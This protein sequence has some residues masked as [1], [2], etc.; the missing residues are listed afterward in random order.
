MLLSISDN[1][2]EKLNIKNKISKLNFAFCILIFG[3]L[4]GSFVFAGANNETVDMV[5][6]AL[7][8]D[9]PAMQSAAVSLVREISGTEFT[10]AL[11]EQFPNLGNVAQ[12]QLLL[13]LADRGDKAALPVVV[14]ATNSKD[15]SVRKA[16][17]E[18]LGKLGDS[19]CVMLLARRAADSGAEEQNAAR[20]SLYCLCGSDIDETVLS[21]IAAETEPKVKVELIRSVGERNIVQG[22][23]TLLK[24]ARDTDRAVQRESLKVLKIIAGPSYLPALIELL[25]D[26]PSESVREIAENT[27]AAV[28]RK[29]EGKNHQVGV[30]LAVLAGVE[31]TESRCS[32][33]S[34][35]GKIGDDSGLP[36]LRKALKDDEV[37]IREAAIRA[38]SDWPS[39]KP[40]SDV[41]NVARN[42]SIKL[43]KILALRGYVR[44]IGLDAESPSSEILAMYK[45][46]ME[47]APDVA[48]K[49]RVLSGVSNTR[50]LSALRMAASY[51][52]DASLQTEAESAVVKIA[53]SIFRTH[54]EPCKG[55]LNKVM[56][57]TK[58]EH[59]RQQAQDVLN[60][61]K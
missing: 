16:A 49:K 45:E 2:M 50:S 37:R 42:S 7:K 19:L 41:Q 27:V 31:K 17:L 24:S 55:A 14:D 32:L 5:I 15:C 23:D 1:E 40:L 22:V 26:I 54:Q 11:V 18:A 4:S 6:K 13:A 8:S 56:E 10:K 61:L 3:F 52:D 47:L 29:I 28:A 9:D 51:L 39:A 25:I 35:L 48:E 33:L 30:V 44:L 21:K 46:A 58:N 12:V 34:V 59:I 57:R 43:H 20:E 38:L 53:G 60:Q 36:E